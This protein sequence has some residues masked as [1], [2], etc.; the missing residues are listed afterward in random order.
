MAK[1]LNSVLQDT[2]QDLQGSLGIAVVDLA[3]GLT[4]G[5][6]HVLPYFTQNFLDAAAAGVVEMFE[7]KNIRKIEEQ[8]CNMRGVPRKHSFINDMFF[9]TDKTYH[10]ML[11]VRDKNSVIILITS[12]D[13][14]QGMAWS[15]LRISLPDV[16][17][18]L[19]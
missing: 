15:K 18:Q 17:E 8:M 6:Y 11:T 10:Y 12:K 1:N 4:M 2:V 19:P 5:V 16:V 3:S 9:S 14:N 13:C 7:G